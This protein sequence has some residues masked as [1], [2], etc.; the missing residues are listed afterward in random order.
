MI[1]LEQIGVGA[2]QIENAWKFGADLF[3]HRL[4]CLFV[5]Q[6]PADHTR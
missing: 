4:Q 1:A 2:K 5:F 6:K 3:A